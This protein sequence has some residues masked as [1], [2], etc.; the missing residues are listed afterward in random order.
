MFA[1][2]LPLLRRKVTVIVPVTPVATD[3]ANPSTLIIFIEAVACDRLPTAPRTRFQIAA[4]LMEF[5]ARHSAV[6]A[7]WLIAIVFALTIQHSIVLL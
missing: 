1:I 7:A 5:A 2:C 6:V 3:T 4:K